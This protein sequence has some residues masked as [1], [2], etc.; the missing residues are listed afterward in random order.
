MGYIFGGESDLERAR[1]AGL[2]VLLDP[3]STDVLS[4]LGVAAGWRCAEVAGGAGSIAR[5]LAERVGTT[6]QVVAT[7]LDTRYLAAVETPNLHVL[8]HD[9]TVD[10][11]PGEPFDL[12]HVRALV[13][14]LGD[15]EK[16]LERLAGWVRPGG[17]LLVEDC[18]WTTR[19]PITPAPEF[20][21]L[22]AAGADLASTA[23]S[24]DTAFGRRLPGLLYGLGLVDIECETRTRAT[25][26]GS[27]EAGLWTFGF[28]RT[29]DGLLAAGLVTAEELAMA[30]AVCDDP[31]FLTMG[32]TLVSAWGRVPGT[33]G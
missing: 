22:L 25:R 10:E 11:C 18:D 26:G 28:D 19:F 27:P 29:S 7:D 3:I 33:S 8:C 5:W 24:Y 21:K 16:A 30:Q 14:H 4:R 12:V 13:E 23:F 6:G 2:E 20:E 9:L 31:A 17:W 1:L 15:R 32:P